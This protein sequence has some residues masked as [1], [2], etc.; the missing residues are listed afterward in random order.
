[1][2]VNILSNMAFAGMNFIQ[3]VAASSRCIQSRRPGDVEMSRKTIFFLDLNVLE[4]I[5]FRLVDFF[6]KL[7]KLWT[8]KHLEVA[9]VAARS[10]VQW[11]RF[12][13]L[14]S[15]SASPSTAWGPRGPRWP[16]RP[17]QLTQMV[18]PAVGGPWH[19]NTWHVIALH[20]HIS[21]SSSSHLIS[22]H[23]PMYT[24]TAVDP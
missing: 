3:G 9:D 12:D 22:E 23:I 1:M 8:M 4:N 15:M 2:M 14:G 7:N 16:K 11:E 18:Q 19:S 13:L 5:R 21:S 20:N 6:S 10:Q 17:A 24:W